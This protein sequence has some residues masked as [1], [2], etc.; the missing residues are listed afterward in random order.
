MAL[1]ARIAVIAA[2]AVAVAVLATSAGLYVATARTLQSGTDREL[3]SIADELTHT[4][5]RRGQV[6]SGPRVGDYGGAGGSSR[7]SAPA[8]SRPEASGPGCP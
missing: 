7:C 6:S 4:P 1:R 8:A 2:M 5:R 3:A